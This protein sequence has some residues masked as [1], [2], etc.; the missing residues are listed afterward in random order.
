[1]FLVVTLGNC[2]TEFSET[3]TP[4]RPYIVHVSDRDQCVSIHTKSP[5]TDTQTNNSVK[6]DRQNRMKTNRRSTTSVE[7]QS[8]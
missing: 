4:H 8:K 7:R 5:H 3:S 2:R 1:M 6:P